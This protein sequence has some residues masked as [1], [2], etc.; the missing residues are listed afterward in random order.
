M[1]PKY[2]VKVAIFHVDGQVGGPKCRIKV[3]LS[4]VCGQV[5]GKNTGLNL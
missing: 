3:A 1:G 2:R 5:V 4:L